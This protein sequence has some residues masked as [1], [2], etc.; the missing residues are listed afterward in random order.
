[1]VRKRKDRS[2]EQGTGKM[3]ANPVEEVE[4]RCDQDADAGGDG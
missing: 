1:M 2:L 3:T 4:D